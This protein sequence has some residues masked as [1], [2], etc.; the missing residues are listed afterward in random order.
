[1]Q[2][3]LSRFCSSS[4]GVLVGALVGVLSTACTEEGGTITVLQNQVAEAPD[5][6]IP[7]EPSQATQGVGLFD[8][9]ACAAAAG[10]PDFPLCT[11]YIF[12]PVLRNEAANMTGGTLASQNEIQL[13]G[14]DIELTFVQTEASFNAITALGDRARHSQRFAQRIEPGGTASVAFPLI[15]RTQA[16]L[17]SGQI[18][19]GQLVQVIGRV[20][21]FGRMNAGDVESSI[22]EYPVTLC[23]G[24]VDVDRLFVPTPDD[25]NP[26]NDTPPEREDCFPYQ[27]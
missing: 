19:E 14:A 11:G 22:Y 7:A 17:L 24:C 23:N 6:V 3:T 10:D 8:A 18:P 27:R 15:D 1:M 25:G 16:A 21:I 9:G 4:R 2:S 26:D 13:Q 12:T 5:C 20:R